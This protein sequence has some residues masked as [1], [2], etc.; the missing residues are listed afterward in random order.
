[1]KSANRV[2]VSKSSQSPPFSSSFWNSARLRRCD[3][4]SP[5]F[6]RI[7]RWS[8]EHVT[9]PLSPKL[10]KIWGEKKIKLGNL[11]QKSEDGENSY[12][13]LMQFEE[14]TCTAPEWPIRSP[15]SSSVFRFTKSVAFFD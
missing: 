14:R 4:R 2:K 11:K 12:E 1:M 7:S 9:K 15:V 5:F 8:A 6:H 3:W 10:R 13:S